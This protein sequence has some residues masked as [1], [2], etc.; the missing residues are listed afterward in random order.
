MDRSSAG[1]RLVLPEDQVVRKERF[2][3]EYPDVTIAFTR[4]LGMPG[5]WTGVV[6]IDGSE[7]KVSRYDLGAI[8]DDLEALVAARD[9]DPG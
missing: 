1:P 5:I 8:L 9:K 3:A 4:P 2:L 7:K 6:P